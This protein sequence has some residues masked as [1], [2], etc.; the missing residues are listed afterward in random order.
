MIRPSHTMSEHASTYWAPR[1]Y[2]VE[3]IQ[4]VVLCLLSCAFILLL[5]R[6]VFLW[7]NVL[8]GTQKILLCVK[9]IPLIS[10]TLKLLSI[11]F[12]N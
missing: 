2:M 8:L 5:W 9:Q 7:L 6:G 10:T 11:L 1:R 3:E 4:N 12:Q